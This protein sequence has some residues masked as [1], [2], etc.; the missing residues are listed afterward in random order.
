MMKKRILSLGVLIICSSIMFTGCNKDDN[1]E[2]NR[3]NKLRVMQDDGDTIKLELYFDASKDEENVEV[4][5]EER[6][7]FTDELMGEVIML[8]LIKGPS[9]Q[10]SLK[11]ILPKETKLISFCIS[12][13]IAYVNL[14]EDAQYSM[15]K[16][17]E[18]VILKSLATSLVELESVDSIKIL[19][20]NNNI[21]TLGGN[22][23]V[24]KAFTAET[25]VLLNQSK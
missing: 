12:D 3:N 13:S 17:K 2:L 23:N 19:I 9:V 1:V 5:S 7:L 14:S 4:S 21:E 25:L 20:A 22:F 6:I 16:A 8:E 10:S 24:S 18:E 15:T 11:S